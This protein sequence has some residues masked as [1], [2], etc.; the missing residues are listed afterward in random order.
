MMT[1]VVQ[2]GTGKAAQALGRPV[3]G[4]TGTSN[5]ARDAWFV[6]Y[7]PEYVAG[8]WVGYDDLRPL[9]RGESGA[10]SA[11]P[12]WVDVMKG[13][14]ADTP[15][16]DFPVPAGIEIAKIDPKTGKLAYDGQ[17][18]AIDEVFLEGSVPTE[19][20]TPPDQVDTDTFMMEQLGGGPPTAPSG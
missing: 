8:V 18:D 16:V 14:L 4:K 7:T 19:V 15:A 12:I 1:S 13:M 11:L 5:K 17:P 3:A 9:G 20:A 6:G 2:S 10:S